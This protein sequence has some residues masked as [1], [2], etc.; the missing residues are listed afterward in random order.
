MPKL[1]DP[2]TI[3]GM[4]VKN[5]L[6]Y[7]PMLTF[8][9]D[10]RGAPSPRTFNVHR[11]KAQGGVGLI[12]YEN[13]GVD[14]MTGMGSASIGRDRVIPTYKELTDMVHS[15][16]AKIGLQVGNGSLIGFSFA[17]FL[18]NMN[19]GNPIGPS[20]VDLAEATSAYTLYD[21]TWPEKIK[22]KNFEMQ[23]LSKEQIIALE[24]Q[25]AA[26]AK[27]AVEAGF[28]YLDIH[29]GHGMLHAS[30]LSPWLNKRTDEYGGSFENRCRFHTE[31]IQKMR[32]QI[33]EDVPIFVRFSADELVEN[34]NRIEDGIEI[35]KALEK[36]G[37]D[38]LDV[39]Q[40]I[41]YRNPS[42][43]EIPSY[44]KHGCFIRL[45]DAI[46]KE[47]D[48]P[49]IGVGRIIDPAMADEF[50][51]EGKADI[52]YMGR[53]LICDPET[54]NK[55]FNGRADEIRHCMGC[56]QD[57]SRGCVQDVHGGQTYQELTPSKEPKKIIILGAGIAGLEAARVAKLRGHEV[58]V[59]EKT[60]TVGGLV[61]L[62]AAEYGK[63]DY[64]NSVNY[65]VSQLKKLG[66]RINFNK[67]LTKDDIA[68]L[69]PDILVIA[70]GSEATLPVKLKEKPNVI[71]Q[72]ESILKSKTIG[73]DVVV[74]G[75]EVYWRGG[76][77]TCISL[78]EEGYNVKALVGP[79]KSLGETIKGRQGKR[80]WLLN[81][82][83]RKNVPVYKEAKLVDV[84]DK[85][86]IFLD[87]NG[88]EQSIQ[89]DT[90][91]HCGSRITNGKKLL[92]EFEGVASEI[93]LIGDASKPR[94]I[95][96]AIREAQN[97]AWKLK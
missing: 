12:T 85:E 65:S 9:S 47:V 44:C 83:K 25:F 94:D 58:E 29:S 2:I 53:Q 31:T 82:I 62:L 52:I 67:E 30:F 74:W 39:T 90:L 41:I 66:V 75:L 92:E 34:G 33:G 64:M 15:Y 27:R 86:V 13:S 57:C 20:K 1:S 72:D 42:G 3:R 78:I 50:I 51:R 60:D 45:A 69:N 46:K 8:S 48:I 96:S 23:V 37:A 14:P 18:F 21:P 89:A 36:G 73:K 93:V 4:T 40:G 11:L 79:E 84:T 77:E 10:G 43:I 19:P 17:N 88:V 61:K 91:V 26:G 80:Y 7:P 16:G 81:Y 63:S 35:A 49:V 5:R 56:L 55:Y 54:P 95:N 22:E 68:K 24:D 76:L 59:Y 87:K 32:E 6:G 70:T 38:C 28:D 71:T 97:F